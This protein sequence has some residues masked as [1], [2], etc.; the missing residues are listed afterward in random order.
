MKINACSVAFRHTNITAALLADYTLKGGF[1]GLE[2]WAPHARTFDAD[3]KVLPRRPKV[4]ML[5]GYLPL[6]ESGFSMLEAIRLCKLAQSWGATKLRLFAGSTGS[7]MAGPA[8]RDRIVADL[9]KCAAIAQDH[10]LKI[11]V[12]T[13]PETLA[14]T[15]CATR[16]LLDRL[17]HPAIGI[18]FDVLHVWEAGVDPILAH[19]LLASDVLHFHLKTVSARNKLSVFTPTNI[20]DQWGH[21]DGIC[22]LFEGALNYAA[23]LRN[24]PIDAEMSLEWFGPD[25]SAT[26]R[27]DLIRIRELQTE[28]HSSF[29]RSSNFCPASVGDYSPN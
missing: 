19:A 24:L 13:H 2:I 17:N 20:H 21:R 16:E 11:A 3:W 1:D 27:A 10:G 22:P 14:D 12:E 29:N 23:I 7:A 8:L 18:N 4:P 26:M 28:N 5:A 15:P 25:P 9:R 6:G